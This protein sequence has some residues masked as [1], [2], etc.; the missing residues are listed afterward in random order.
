MPEDDS[1]AVTPP[2][3][4]LTGYTIRVVARL[5][6]LSTDTLRIWERRYGIPKPQR[7]DNG[8]RSYAEGEVSKLLLVVRALRVGYRPSEALR[9]S[10]A[11]LE[12][13]LAR[14]ATVRREAGA[15]VDAIASVL[16]AL[17][18]DD[19]E[20]VGAELRAALNSKGPVEF[21]EQFVGPLTHQLGEAWER[22]LLQIR[23]E[24]LMAELLSTQ[25]RSMRAAWERP[26]MR[27][28]LV[29]ATAAGE[30]HSLGVLMVGAWMAQRS[31]PLVVLGVDVPL[32]ELVEAVKAN[33]GAVLALSFSAASSPA[34]AHEQVRWLRAAIAPTI[35]LWIGGQGA[36]TLAPIEGVDLVA[37]WEALSAAVERVFKPM[38]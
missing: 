25:L 9:L 35:G 6:G 2:G 21:I 38:P 30:Q 19:L 14:S 5:T 13:L 22:G 29:L 34:R 33:R 8:I 17:R 24:H 15:P 28:P 7:E 11:E 12:A 31:V 27:A 37:S 36:T 20:R 26:S 32:A 4:P 1:A 23:H 16:D 18:C 10:P 3:V